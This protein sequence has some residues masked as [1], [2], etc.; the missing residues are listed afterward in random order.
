MAN[1][2]RKFR[3][4]LDSTENRCSKYFKQY[5]CN[6]IEQ[7]TS[8]FRARTIVNTNRFLESFHRTLKVVY[9]QQKQNRID[10]LLH[11]LLKIAKTQSREGKVYSQSS[12]LK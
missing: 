5:Y 2:E 7:W 6:R 3:Y 8:C 10:F 1:E 4:L 11:T 9:L 12:Y